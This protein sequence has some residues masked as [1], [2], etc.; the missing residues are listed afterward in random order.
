MDGTSTLVVWRIG[1][2]LNGMLE[3]YVQLLSKVLAGALAGSVYYEQFPF[4]L[5]V[6]Y[7]V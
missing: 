4:V 1:S 6:S 5:Y 3:P 2:H 7:L